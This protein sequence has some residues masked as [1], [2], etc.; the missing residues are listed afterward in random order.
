MT[1][2]C[3]IVVP[4]ES[5]G[6]HAILEL[7]ITVLLRC[8]LSL[9]LLYRWVCVWLWPLPNLPQTFRGRQPQRSLELKGY[10]RTLATP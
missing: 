8:A 9:R 3:W 2:P 5:G 10:G 7:I 1:I 4:M 6:L